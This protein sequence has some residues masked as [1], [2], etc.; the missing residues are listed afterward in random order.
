MYT[1]TCSLMAENVVT[2]RRTE[3]PNDKS[4]TCVCT[5]SFAVHAR[6]GLITKAHTVKPY[7]VLP[8]S[9]NY[10][11]LSSSIYPQSTVELHTQCTCTIM[12]PAT[13]IYM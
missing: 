5:I 10:K 11:L 1:C 13:C 12:L 9:I 3:G 4:S 8:C 6:R 7:V 2:D